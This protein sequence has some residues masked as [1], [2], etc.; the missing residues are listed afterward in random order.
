MRQVFVIGVGMTRFGKHLDKNLKELGRTAVMNAVRDADISPKELEYAYVANSLAGLITGQEGIRG[1][2]ILR[3]MGIGEIPII[4]V[5]NACAGGSTAFF[6]AWLAVGSGM[7]DIAL[8]L[9]IEKLFCDNTSKSLAALA[10]CTDVEFEGRMG[11]LFPG[12]YAMRLKKHMKEYGTTKE[13]MALVT[14]KNHHN[15][16]L[17]PFA[18]YQSE[19]TMKEVLGSRMIAD[20]ITLLMTAPMGDGAAAAI[21]GSR[22]TSR[23]L[24]SRSVLV[25]STA[26]KSA[27]FNDINSEDHKGIVERTGSLAYERAG[28]GPEDIEVAEVHDAMAPAEILHYEHLGFC[29]PGEGGRLIQEGITRLN[30]KKPVNT[31]G[32]LASRGHPVAATGLAQIA[33]IVWQLRGEA[34]KR[35]LEPTPKVGLI[36]NGGGNLGGEAASMAV[37]ILKK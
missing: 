16:S 20:P 2:T 21:L 5:E 29:L 24:R 35:Q 14:I 22:K 7:C 1:Q 36:Q 18:Q 23:K 12:I 3:E 15:G 19:V 8:A 9:G 27:S 10:T 33:E 34:G 17:N 37:H 13:Q 6:N 32:G 28:I 26:M 4:N 25:A 31:S 30:G 11:I